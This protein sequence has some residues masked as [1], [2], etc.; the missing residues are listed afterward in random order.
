MDGTLF[1]S[2]NFPGY[3]TYKEFNSK[4]SEALRGQPVQT[5]GFLDF[6]TRM[7]VSRQSLDSLYSALGGFAFEGTLNFVLNQG[8]SNALNMTTSLEVTDVSTDPI[9]RNL[10]GVPSDYTMT[11]P[12]RVMAPMQNP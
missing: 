6:M 4:T 7:G 3:D 9:D 11:D 12:M 8:L 10:F 2:D 1:V 5:G